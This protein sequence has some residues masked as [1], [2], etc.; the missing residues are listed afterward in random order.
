MTV[1]AVSPVYETAAA[2][3]TDQP[4]FLNAAVTGT[5][6]LEPL[7]LLHA[8]K[9]LENEI[10]RQPSFRYGPRLLDIDIL[11][12]NAEIIHEPGLIIPHPEIQNRR[13][14][15]APMNEIAPGFIHP[16]FLKSISTLLKECGDK[17]NVKKI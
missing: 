10:G 4:A 12:F 9:Q 15:L 13:F 11:F 1:T 7:A 17:L 16:V 5:T 8:L 2:Y 3:V 14:A 6:K